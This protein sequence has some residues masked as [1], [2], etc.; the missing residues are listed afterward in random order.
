M[1][2]D[3]KEVLA[4]AAKSVFGAI[5][6][7]GSLL[8]EVVF[9]YSTRIKQNRLNNFIEI[10][11]YGFNENS[12]IDLDNIKSED[13]LDLFES[14]LRRVV[15]TKSESKLRKY[16]DIL[17]KELR[18]PSN[19]IELVELYL[20]LITD[21]SEEELTILYHHRHFTLDY[22]EKIDDMNKL[23]THLDTVKHKMEKEWK[24]NGESRYKRERKELE[25]KIEAIKVWL[26]QLSIYRTA[27]F[28]ALNDNKFMLFKQRLSSKGL[29]L[30]NRKNRI[31]GVTFQNMGITEFGE[32]FLEFITGNQE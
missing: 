7:G 16:K 13:F 23:R 2:L 4:S 11:S 30:D 18:S 20:D 6:F 31:S 25:E 15:R 28:Y 12:G 10:L 22:E 27:E 26:S 24:G 17:I 9:E 29:L 1:N 3:K 14:V 21:L 19:Q 8:D 5:P 32:E